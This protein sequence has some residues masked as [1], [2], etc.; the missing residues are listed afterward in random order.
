M[1]RPE[2]PPVHTYSHYLRSRY[3]ETDKMGYVYYGRYLEFFEVARTEMIRD[4]GLPYKE[5]EDQG[6][7]LPVVYAEA[8]YHAPVFYDEEME[9][10]VSIHEPPLARLDT[11]YNVFTTRQTVP[12]VTGRVTLAFID[13]A[14]RRPRRAPAHFIDRLSPM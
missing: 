11:W 6:I 12:H 4:L 3:S 13:A 2:N 1:T 10:R 8:G 5:L 14:T 9:I 7:L